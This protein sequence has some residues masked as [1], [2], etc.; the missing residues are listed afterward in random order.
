M[1]FPMISGI[2]PSYGRTVSVISSFPS[3][4]WKVYW[5]LAIK[6]LEQIEIICLQT[7]ETLL[8]IC[9]KKEGLPGCLCRI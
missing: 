1:I 2:F 4:F 5:L 8:E 3:V 6:I 9:T 7:A